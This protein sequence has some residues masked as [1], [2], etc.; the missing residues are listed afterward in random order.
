M[1]LNISESS[2]ADVIKKGP[3]KLGNET[4]SYNLE[5]TVFFEAGCPDSNH[6]FSSVL[7]PQ[8]QSFSPVLSLD[9][10]PWGNAKVGDQNT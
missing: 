7:R 6:F 1:F 3:F 4:C 5:L 8:Y 2:G 9:L 10:I